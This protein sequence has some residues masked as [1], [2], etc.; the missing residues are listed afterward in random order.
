M[1]KHLNKLLV[2]CGY[3]IVK[4]SRFRE[5]I[6][7][8]YKNK[9]KIHFVQVGAND[10]IRFDDLYSFVTNIDCRGIV[11]EPLPDFYEILSAVYRL[12]PHI[13]T[14]RLALHPTDKECTLYRVDPKRLGELP[15]WA[16]GI[17]S[18]DPKHHEKT[19]VPGEYIIEERVKATTL[20]ELI[21]D[22]GF[23]EVDLLQIDVEGFDGEV[24]K[25]L[26]FETIKPAIIKYEHG[27]LRVDE[28]NE[29]E[30]LLLFHGY[31]L[32]REGPDT[33][34]YQ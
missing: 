22:G 34:A 10:G 14:K 6:H 23:E 20:M 5:L 25:M 9:G 12:Y 7:K 1:R 28:K 18:L 15:P 27:N 16:A 17:A 4:V 8:Y 31:K 29:V 24:I 11:V 26:E 32:F 2:K 19:K 21:K 3:K 33:I 30:E 13:E